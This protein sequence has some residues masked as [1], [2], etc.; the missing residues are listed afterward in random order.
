MAPP[1][2]ETAGTTISLI[3]N[4]VRHHA[5]D[6]G[7][8]RL[9]ELAGETRPLSEL[10]DEQRWSTYEQ[11]IALM[12]AAAVVLD[13]PNVMI[14]M[15]EAALEH[16]VGPGIRILIRRLGSPR[17]VLANVARACPKF[18]TVAT[19][20]AEHLGKDDAI[21]TYRLDPEKTPNRFDCQLNV[22]FMRTIGPIFGIPPLDVEHPE[23]QVLGAPVCRYV[24][25]WT[26][27]RGRRRREKARERA[28]QHQV[29]ELEAQL[30]LLQ[31]TTS[32]LVSADEIDD[33][34]AR[35][36]TR[37]GSAT[38][39]TRYLLALYDTVPVNERLHADGI[40]ADAIVPTAAEIL[41]APLGAD[42][43]RIVIEVASSRQAYGRLAALYDH[44]TFFD[45]EEERLAAYAQS[46][47][48]ALDAATALDRAR[49][50]S[51]TTSALLGLARD[52]AEPATPHRIARTVAHAMTEILE[53][54]ATA[55]LLWD[56]D[57]E[58]LRVA[59]RSGWPVETGRF[60]SDFRLPA[61]NF[62]RLAASLEVDGA[63]VVEVNENATNPL[64][65]DL[66]V[67]DVPMLAVAPVRAHQGEAYGLAIAAV[68]DVE[69]HRLDAIVERLV[70]IG[71]QAAIALQ[72]A[73]LLEQIRHQAVH[74]NLTGLANRALFDSELEKVL[75]RAGRDQVPVTVLF[76]DLDD[77]KSV[78]DRA[79]HGAG[80]HVL[81]TVAARL[82]GAGRKGDSV[83]RLGGDEF[84]M[85]L[86]G[87][88]REDA[89]Q[90]A[91]RVARAICEPIVLGEE[92]LTIHASVG[93]ATAREDGEDAETLLRAADRSMYRVKRA[94][95]VPTAVTHAGGASA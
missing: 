53:V 32:D 93:L 95:R 68:P 4:F 42:G 81:R 38:S 39:A 55:I 85:L 8:A 56:D 11:K 44:H 60:M 17:M 83:A 49:R 51:V 41:R 91:Q 34:L 67:L 59:G 26:N 5:G 77:F 15:G 9:L 63:R 92:L 43:N 27:P 23:C 35:I 75:A 31:S 66:Q 65:R 74:D 2:R 57:R 78:N 79:G 86:P 80:D 88:N 64:V 24:V 87:S 28:L 52:L 47:A 89:A 19:M 70:A 21:V 84:T 71:D 54:P 20:T 50:R 61:A 94:E 58:H 82:V 18:S 73:Q 12:E 76:I 16:Q 48:A 69:Q 10:E 7:V 37:A 36:V 25:R 90:I 22:G 13:D 62:R 1:A 40:D 3:V 33:V 30:A 46:A 14:H 29:D 72:N 6:D 45:F